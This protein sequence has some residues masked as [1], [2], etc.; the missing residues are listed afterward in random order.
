[1]RSGGSRSAMFLRLLARAAVWRKGQALSALLSVTVAAAAVSAM[2]DLMVDVE[3]KLRREFRSYGANILVEAGSRKSFSP[4]ELARIYSALADRGLAVPFAYTVARTEKDQAVVVAAT[5]FA[6][7]RKLNPWWAVSSWPEHSGQALVGVRAARL[8]PANGSPFRLRFAGTDISL[9]RAGTVQTGAG[10]D[11]RIYVSLDDFSSWTGLKPSVV[12]IA[13]Y[14]ARGE[15]ASILNDLGRAV[16]S[17]DVRPVRQVTE[18][19]AGVLGKTRS[20]LLSSAAL[21]A[22]TAALSVVATLMGWVFDRRRDFA[23]MKA[24]GASERLITLFVLGQA[25]LLGAA[26]AIGGF[27]IG[28]GIAAWI[29]RANFHAPVVP[30][31]TILPAIVAGSLAVTLVSTLLPLR[32]LRRIQPAMILRGE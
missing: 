11:S 4:Q 6:L 28:V 3:A 14:G 9:R 22:A 12:E 23:I 7:V 16:P 32:L 17:A 18:A 24:L 8:L 27:A 26:G 30:R 5:D 31:L 15:I 13:A 10:E 19:E 25:A 1:M 21:I 2:F 29:G 20:T